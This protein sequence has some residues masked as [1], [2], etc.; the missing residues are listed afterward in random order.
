MHGRVARK[1]WD[2]RTSSV[3]SVWNGSFLRLLS[4]FHYL[5]RRLA[6]AKVLWR[7][8]SHCHAVCVSA[9]LVSVAKVMRGCLYPVLSS[10]LYILITLLCRWL[11]KLFRTRQGRFCVGA[12]GIWY[13][14]KFTCCPQ[15]QKL[16]GKCRP[17]WSSYFFR[18]RRT[19]KWTR[20]WRGWW[21][22]EPSSPEFLG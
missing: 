16:A 11:S 20:W 5:R 12:G 18:F 4:C 7:S 17:L 22:S 6:R 2:E 15:I 21:G 1:M 10:F 8:A 14:P 3:M 13:A 9:A 19:D